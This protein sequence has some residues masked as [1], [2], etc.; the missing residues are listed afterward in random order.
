[1]GQ[2]EILLGHSFAS[3]FDLLHL[4]S[5]KSLVFSS[6]VREEKAQK[7][8]Q[9]PP[10]DTRVLGDIGGAGRQHLVWCLVWENR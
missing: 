7:M 10:E 2:E 4:N 1:M 8:D 6:G 3:V 5:R 9:S